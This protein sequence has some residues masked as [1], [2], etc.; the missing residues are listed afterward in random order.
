MDPD[1]TLETVLRNQTAHSPSK[2][3][4]RW[5]GSHGN[6][7]SILLHSI[8]GDQEQLHLYSG[9]DVR[10]WSPRSGCGVLLS[11]LCRKQ[12]R[13]FTLHRLLCEKEL[14]QLVLR[15]EVDLKQWDLLIPEAA[16]VGYAILLQDG[17]EITGD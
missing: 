4:C 9:G 7:P 11:K 17:L 3:S 5:N 6:N 15:G 16:H 13:Q 8:R 2:E 10:R 12:G 14:S 1:G